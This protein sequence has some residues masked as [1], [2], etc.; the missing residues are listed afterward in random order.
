MGLMR[1]IVNKGAVKRV[2]AVLVVGLALGSGLFV[3]S[4]CSQGEAPG[5]AGY[6]RGRHAGMSVRYSVKE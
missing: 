3:E 2:A 1:T 6:E 5:Y 4:G